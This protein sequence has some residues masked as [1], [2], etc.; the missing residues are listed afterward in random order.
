MEFLEAFAD[1]AALA[2]ENA[3]I[4]RRLEQENERLQ[5]A[6]EAR[7]HFGNII[8][9]SA[10]MRE[11]RVILFSVVG[12]PLRQPLEVDENAELAGL[13]DSTPGGKSGLRR[14]LPF[15]RFKSAGRRS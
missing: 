9:E 13:P 5:V 2:L 1:H 8:G 7:A 15:F 4:R 14:F 6:A 11:L 10:P 12:W 3:R